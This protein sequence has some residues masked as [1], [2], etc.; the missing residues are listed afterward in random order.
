[1]KLDELHPFAQELMTVFRVK[2]GPLDAEYEMAKELIR[3]NLYMDKLEKRIN[4]LEK[5]FH[6][7]FHRLKPN[8]IVSIPSTPEVYPVDDDAWLETAKGGYDE[9]R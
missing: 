9:G 1:M 2:Y 8:Q 3:M 7:A 4:Y 6:H 5:D